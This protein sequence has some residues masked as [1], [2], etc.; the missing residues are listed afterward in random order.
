[1]R[2]SMSREAPVSAA[3]AFRVDLVADL[4]DALV[5]DAPLALGFAF[6]LRP[7]TVRFSNP[8]LRG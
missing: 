8:I 3:P 7:A 1:M 4:C 5:R 6:L 2:W